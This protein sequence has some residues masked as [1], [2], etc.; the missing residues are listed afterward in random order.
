MENFA[1]GMLRETNQ[2]STFITIEKALLMQLHLS[3][4]FIFKIIGNKTPE[5]WVQSK[6]RANK[7]QWDR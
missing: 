7:N 6:T 4:G 5:I 2:I 3:L 1:S